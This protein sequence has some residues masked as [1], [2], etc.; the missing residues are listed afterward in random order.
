MSKPMFE[1]RRRCWRADT[2]DSANAK[3]AVADDDC[4][5]A[6]ADVHLLGEATHITFSKII[7][8]A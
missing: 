7:L 6:D 2:D 8:K 3:T 4:G 5:C 1:L